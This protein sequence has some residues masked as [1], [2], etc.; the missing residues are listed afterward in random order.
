MRAGRPCI[1]HEVQEQGKGDWQPTSPEHGG[2]NL[3]ADGHK[4]ASL[5]TAWHIEPRTTKQQTLMP[6]RFMVSSMRPS[7]A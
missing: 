3:L 6:P 2:Y 4:K 1:A 5:E 7:A